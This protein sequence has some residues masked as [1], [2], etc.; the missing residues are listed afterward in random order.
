[1]VLGPTLV[2]TVAW[3]TTGLRDSVQVAN[4]ALV[5]AAVTVAVAMA[6]W[7]AGLLTS[8]V[9]ALSLNYFHTLPL[10]SLRIT[11]SSDIESVVLLAG[12]GIVTSL[13][14]AAR[15]RSLAKEHHQSKAS[16]S[17]ILLATASSSDRPVMVMW[18][19]AVQA[20]CAGLSLVD[21]RLEPVGASKVPSIARHRPSVDQPT[22]F[23]LPE[24]GA[25]VSFHDPR[26]TVQV[27]LTPHRGVGPLE[28]DRSVVLAFVDQLELVVAS[29]TVTR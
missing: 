19:E 10:H 2:L 9:G 5:M 20:A 12:I 23:I 16:E 26:S 14:T 11:T 18:I 24:G 4:V 29:N 21:C 17:R 22:A 3:A 1:M 6:N 27:T 25:S 28:L 15:V 8:V 7:A 13:A